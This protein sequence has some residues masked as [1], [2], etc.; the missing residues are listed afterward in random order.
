MTPEAEPRLNTLKS[1]AGQLNISPNTLIMAWLRHSDPVV[2]PVIG[3][4][5]DAQLDESLAAVEV[6]LAAEHMAAL[7][8]GLP[9]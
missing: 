1:M 4:S 7:N 8:E 2:I 5:T 9:V 3:A 6:S